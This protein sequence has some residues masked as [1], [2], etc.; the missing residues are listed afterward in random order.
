MRIIPFVVLSAAVFTGGALIPRTG[1]G[2]DSGTDTAFICGTSIPAGPAARLAGMNEQLRSVR[3]V[4]IAGRE[5]IVITGADSVTREYI[6]K[7]GVLWANSDPLVTDVCF[8]HF[9]YR[10]RFGNLIVRPEK[11]REEIESIAYILSFKAD[12]G[13]IN[14]HFSTDHPIVLSGS[15]AMTF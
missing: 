3:R 2:C 6:V 8:F 15:L 14:A 12:P 10:D 11:D 7:N 5:R 13:M 4:C 9:E 1:G